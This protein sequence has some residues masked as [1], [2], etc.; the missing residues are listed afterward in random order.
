M[1]T[2]TGGG[3]PEV[4]DVYSEDGYYAVIPEW[5]LDAD[6]SAQAV[7][8]YAVLRR[9]ADQR[10]MHANPSR[11]TLAGRIQVKDEKVVDRALADLQR[12]GAVSIIPR[13]RNEDGHIAYAPDGEHRER[14][15]N[16]YQLHRAPKSIP[17]VE[18]RGGG[19]SAPTPGPGSPHPGGAGAPTVG[20]QKGEEPQPCEPQPSEPQSPT[21]TELVSAPDD[22][23]QL[24]LVDAPAKP[25]KGKR[26]T[27]IPADWT[28]SPELRAK[29][30]TR[31]PWLDIDREVERFRNHFLG[32][33][34]RWME[35]DRAWMNWVDRCDPPRGRRA[36][37]AP[38]R[39]TGWE[40]GSASAAWDRF[41]GQEDTDDQQQQ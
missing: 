34:K 39:N 4:A 26:A 9:Y 13:W 16:G 40:N 35:W 6:I 18:G 25:A 3:P 28:P 7:R 33:G 31:A 5:V 21:P 27:R 38:Y 30:E 41:M 19:F 20:A 14:T 15:S 29:T 11:K 8:L 22:A 23:P 37:P 10:T 2:P 1:T 32:T 12:I 17:S 36:Q 24:S